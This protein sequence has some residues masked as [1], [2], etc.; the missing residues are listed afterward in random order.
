MRTVV[1]FRG[2]DLRLADHAPLVAAIAAGEVIPLFVLDP[3]FFAPERA[4]V[5]PHRVQVLLESLVALRDALAAKGTRLVTVAGRSVDVVPTLA[6]SWRAD[7]VIAQRWT[8]PVGRERD[9]RVAAALPCPFELLDGETLHRPGSLRT[10]S[11]GPY[12]VFTPFARA[13]RVRAAV[14]MPLPEPE[15]IPPLPADV[16][17]PSEPI[18]TLESLGIPHNPRVLRGGEEAGWRRLHCFLDGPGDGYP[19][20]RDRMDLDGTSR[21]SVDLK[22]GTLSPRQVWHA[23]GA[24]L[25]GEALRRFEDELLWREFAHSILHER[26]DVLTEPFNERYRGFPYRDDEVGWQAWVSGHTGYPVV[27]AAARQ[28]LA[29]GFVHNRA[30]M[31]AASFLTKHQLIDFRRGEDHYLRWLADGDAPPNDAGW[32]WSAG[33][34]CDAQPWFRIF[35]PVTQGRRFDPDGAY[36]R[37]WVPELGRLPDRWI[38][39]PWEAPSATLRSAGITLGRDYPRP[40]VDHRA[41][42]ERFLTVARAHLDR[43]SGGV[44]EEDPSGTDLR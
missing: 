15:H 17:T 33:C 16:T 24:A 43:A 11:G 41:A 42:R 25:H 20:L 22:F 35:N 26:P 8:D 7:R 31:I 38:H 19:E 23:V 9:R 34:G 4:Q 5:I 6:R 21:I 29:T 32:Q 14:G 13:F 36:V 40:I 37:R 2:K 44:E 10:G 27:D 12:G 1:W 39:A 18:P 28:L 3:Y 30:R